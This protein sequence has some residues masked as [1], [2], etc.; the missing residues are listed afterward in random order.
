MTSWLHAHRPD[1]DEGTHDQL[2]G[3]AYAAVRDKWEHFGF[4]AE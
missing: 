2:G 1:G 4:M 3:L